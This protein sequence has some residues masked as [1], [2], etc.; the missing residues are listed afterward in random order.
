MRVPWLEVVRCLSPKSFETSAQGVESYT[1]KKTIG[2]SIPIL[3]Q[4]L[5]TEFVYPCYAVR[6]SPETI[7]PLKQKDTWQAVK[8]QDGDR[9]HEGSLRLQ[10]F[11]KAGCH[12]DQREIQGFGFRVEGDS[13]EIQGYE[14]TITWVLIEGCMGV[15]L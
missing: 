14:G 4:A 15:S 10:T 1:Q 8:A 13:S 6:R 12:E 3:A 11:R 7:L 5:K 2:L 9:D